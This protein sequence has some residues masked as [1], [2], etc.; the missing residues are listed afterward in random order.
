MKIKKSVHINVDQKKN[1]QKDF[2]LNRLLPLQIN[3]TLVSFVV[4]WLSQYFSQDGNP[5]MIEKISFRVMDQPWMPPGQTSFPVFGL[6]HFGDW[7]LDMGWAMI[8]NCYTLPDYRCPKPPLGNWILRIFG[9]WSNNYSFAYFVW[10]LIATLVFFNAIKMVTP[11]LKLIQK[12]S[13]LWFGVILSVGNVISFDRGSMHFMAYA[14]LTNAIVYSFQNRN[15]RALTFFIIAV[16]LK[17]QLLLVSIFLLNDKKIIKFLWATAAPIVLN[18]LIMFTY[19]GN[20]IA[21]IKGYLGA[22]GGY[23][24]SADSLGNIMN[25]VSLIGFYSRYLEFLS[26]SDVAMKKLATLDKMMILPGICWILITALFVY[27]SSAHLVIKLILSLALTSLS[28]PS[29]GPYLMGWISIIGFI[30]LLENSN[31]TEKLKIEIQKPLDFSEKL[32][33]SGITVAGGIILFVSPFPV[34]GFG[35]QLPLAPLVPIF[36]GLLMLSHL[37][38]SLKMRSGKLGKTI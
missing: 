24:S 7:N 14:L 37:K 36:L 22:S 16:S 32:L 19:P 10:I 33:I 20:F 1:S 18:A 38:K 34:L 27:F 12:T 35:R 15:K 25:S 9:I 21:N 8:D 6:H 3:L 4:T 2:Y 17:P 31:I 29:S 11:K 30:L 13:F 26:G 5:K 28:V 23:V